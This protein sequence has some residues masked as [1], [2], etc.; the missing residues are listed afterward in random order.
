AMGSVVVIRPLPSLP[1]RLDD[2]RQIA[3]ERQF[4]EADAA[5]AEAAN[6]GAR[7][8]AAAAAVVSA[9]RKLRFAFL[10]LNQ[11]GLGQA[12]SSYDFRNGIFMNVSRRRASSSVFAEVTIVI[13]IP[14]ILSILS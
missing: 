13:F 2:A 9:R 12:C 4:A 3:G 7:A 10:L 11:T 8:A 14:R 5:N 1:T 6:K